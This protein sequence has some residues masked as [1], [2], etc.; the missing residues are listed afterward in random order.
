MCALSAIASQLQLPRES[1]VAFLT[2]LVVQLWQC[3]WCM[4]TMCPNMQLSQCTVEISCRHPDWLISHDKWSA[5]TWP[6]AWLLGSI[7]LHSVLVAIARLRHSV[8]PTGY[9]CSP[10]E[11]TRVALLG[12]TWLALHTICYFTMVTC[13]ACS[14]CGCETCLEV[15]PCALVF[16]LKVPWQRLHWQPT[17]GRR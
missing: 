8:V 11:V 1:H 2:F 9:Y 16:S 3:E 4:R 15:C 14:V 7:L 5:F 12:I 13:D 6:L 10:T 17:L